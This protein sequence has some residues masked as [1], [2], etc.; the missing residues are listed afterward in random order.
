MLAAILGSFLI[1]SLRP[2]AICSLQSKTREECY[3]LRHGKIW[4]NVSITV[5]KKMK[6]TSPAIVSIYLYIYLSIYLSV[7][8]SL[9]LSICFSLSL[10][11]FISLCVRCTSDV[12]ILWVQF[13]ISYYSQLIWCLIKISYLK[14][15]WAAKHSF[16]I[17][18]ELQPGSFLE[19][20]VVASSFLLWPQFGHFLHFWSQTEHSRL[21][22][23]TVSTEKEIPGGP[24]T[25]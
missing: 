13:T 2:I 15:N 20:K 7:Y 24:P 11:I 1:G 8:L 12:S 25:P 18:Q 21:I 16:F 5:P 6:D 22:G 14:I 3:S 9:C 19:C 23:I 17:S 4:E 10:S